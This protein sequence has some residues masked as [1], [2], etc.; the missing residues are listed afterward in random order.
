MTSLRRIGWLAL[1]LAAILPALPA[2]PDPV[3]GAWR[4]TIT[5]PQGTVADF[6][7]EFFRTPRGTLVF[8]L[9][10]PDM[11]TYAA[12]FMIPVEADGAG[13]YR[14]AP[15]FQLQLELKGDTLAGTFGSGRL[16]VIL[17]RTASFPPK[18]APVTHPAA[19]AT[20]WHLDLGAPTWAP[21][22]AAD[23]VI[24]IGTSAGRVYAVRARDG[25]PLWSW[26]GGH[27]IDGAAVVEADSV[28]VLDTRLE[29]HALDRHSGVLRWTTPLHDAKLAGGPVPDNPTFNHR[30]AR[31]LVWDGTVYCGSSDG[32]LYA[33]DAASGQ[34]Q[35]RHAAGAPIYS[36]VGRTGTDTL[37]FGTMDGSVVLLDRRTRQETARF[38]TGGGVVTTPVVAAGNVIVGSRDYLLH[39]F[40]LRDGA[41]AW[42]FSYWFS[43]IESTP[44]LVDGLIYVGASDYSRVTAF[45]P[46]TGR[47]RWATPVHGMNWGTPL[48][49]ADRVFTGTVAQ[50]LPGT[51]IAHV[52]G[53]VAL[54]RTSGEVCWQL[55]APPAP[56]NG[57][58]GYAGSLAL[59]DGL[60]IAAGLDGQLLALPAH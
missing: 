53:L 55:P 17:H 21:P 48:V 52:G 47:V 27:A 1:G 50:N 23:G 56:P 19:P 31:P 11:F 34:V 13:H 28:Y 43:W 30:A 38:R 25:R 51:V 60:V 29:L 12:P 36:G 49:T 58:G 15:A 20:V 2:A 54:D 32:G 10:F 8:R 37:M 42:T 39:A 3:E 26:D 35:W 57:F 44:V 5:A 33:I 4:G 41:K 16:P 14:I 18:P 59:A 9:Y 40:R 7:L 22:V 24:Y 45:D 6:G 46:A